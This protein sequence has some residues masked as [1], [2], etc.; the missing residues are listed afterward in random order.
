MGGVK[1]FSN[2]EIMLV[3]GEKLDQKQ[4]GIFTEHLAVWT[5]FKSSWI[6]FKKSLAL[7]QIQKFYTKTF[8]SMCKRKH[9]KIVL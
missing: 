3:L 9:F 4:K 5:V 6:Q 1:L 7:V 8:W 2:L